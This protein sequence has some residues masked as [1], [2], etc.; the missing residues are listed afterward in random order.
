MSYITP[1]KTGYRALVEIKK[2]RASKTFAKKRDAQAWAAAKEAEFRALA[3][4]SGGSIKTLADALNRYAEEVSPTKRGERWELIRLKAFQSAD[5]S[6]LPVKNKLQ[7][8]T[9]AHL[10]DWRD[11]RLKKVKPGT[12]LRDMDLLAVVF[13]I[14][15]REWQWIKTN[16]LLDLRRPA[17]PAHR[18]RIISWREIRLI[19]NTLGYR[20]G[21][22][23]SV[24]QAVAVCFIVALNTGMRAGELCGLTWDRVHPD[25]ARLLT[26]KN[27]TPR[28]VPLT[29]RAYRVIELM[30][31]WDNNLVFGLNARV[32]DTVFRRAREKAG[33]SGFT[34]HDSRHTAATILAPRMDVLDLAKMFGWKNVNQSMVYYNP[35]ASQIKSRIR[36]R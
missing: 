29:S 15:R 5:H 19:L 22:V 6:P 24:P 10:A 33:L 28:D 32:L 36:A 27:G 14:A 26:T 8:I 4:G 7:D 11:V 31:G 16:P 20:F 35:T 18:D 13:D 2:Q 12:V 23:R 9:T 30:R 25:Y 3:G 34:F 17:A 21:S 1:T